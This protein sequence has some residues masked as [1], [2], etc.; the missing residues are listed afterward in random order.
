M[1]DASNSE[2]RRLVAQNVV[3]IND[4]KATDPNQIF[5]TDKTLFVR[6]GR[7]TFFKVLA[8]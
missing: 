6:V 3:T 8:K 5:Q 4:N 7:K 2:L 1:P